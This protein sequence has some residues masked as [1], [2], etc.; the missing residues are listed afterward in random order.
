M[1]ICALSDLHGNLI[2]IEYTN[3]DCLFICGDITP[4]EIQFNYEKVFNWV[5]EYFIPWCKD[6]DVKNI[7]LVGGNHDIYFEN[8]AKKLKNI[9][10]GT[11]I[12]YLCN[13][14]AEYTNS[15]GKTYVIFGSPDCQ[16][17][18]NWAFGNWAFMYSPKKELGNFN[19][20]PKNCDILLTHDAA[21]RESDV[22]LGDQEHLGNRELKE[23]LDKRRVEGIAPKYHF[24]GHL[25]S[26]DHNIVNY[27]GINTACVSI[28]DNKYDYKYSP[29]VMDI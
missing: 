2:P 6:I 12:T 26:C 9:F 10:S 28:V 23:I 4:L 16:I 17:F 5:R 7:Y 14:S 20:M 21:Y 19:K 11:N 24:F 8:S 29:L 27:D 25:H 22:L 18:G 1:K 13:E 3:L 15:E